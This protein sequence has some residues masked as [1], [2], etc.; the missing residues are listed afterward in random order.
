MDKRNLI[1][2]T[3]VELFT[4]WKKVWSYLTTVED[5]EDLE[6]LQDMHL[7]LMEQ[8][9][10]EQYAMDKQQLINDAYTIGF[11]EV[12]VNRLIEDYFMWQ[13]IRNE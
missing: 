8:I 11:D 1:E 10:D 7:C 6:Y 2:D 5:I 13:E 9:F 12:D 4:T 3:K